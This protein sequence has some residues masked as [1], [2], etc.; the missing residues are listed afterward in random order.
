MKSNFSTTKKFY[1]IGL[2][3]IFIAFQKSSAQINLNAEPLKERI[4]FT[5]KI[6]P[7]CDSIISKLKPNIKAGLALDIS[8]GEI[9]WDYNSDKPCEIASLTKIMVELLAM[10]KLEGKKVKLGDTVNVTKE[11]T[12]IGGSH[13]PLKTGDKFPLEDLLRAALIFS[14][15]NAAYLVGCY[16][17]GS[18]TNFI[19]MMNDRA[20]ELGLHHTKFWNPTGLPP[21]RKKRN[22]VNVS[23]CI[24]LAVLSL[25]LLEYSYI[26]DWM[27]T[28]FSSFNNGAFLMRTRNSLM[29][30]CS[31]V[32]GL[33]TGYY[34][35]AGHNI[36]A[37]SLN[38]NR[39]IMVIILGAKS[40]QTRDSA[41]K[42]LIQYALSKPLDLKPRKL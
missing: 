20:S 32:D 22:E 3:T 14:A 7:A 19:K 41:A 38:G 23:N 31:F 17:G 8:S 29:R 35:R 34:P 24:D 15:N 36:V 6:D 37:T 16:I 10:E 40:R 12:C 42:E 39:K 21:T 18:E 11:A 5:K 13:V 2:L 4:Q 9:F 30:H 33:K 26:K 27:S 28:K 25:Q 1:F